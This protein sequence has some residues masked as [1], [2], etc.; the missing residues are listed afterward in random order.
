MAAV[1]K[2]LAKRTVILLGSSG[3]GSKFR[4][5]TP[6]VKEDSSNMKADSQMGCL[7]AMEGLHRLLGF[8]LGSLKMA[9]GAV[10]VV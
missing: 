8:S 4:E 9:L 2:L 6:G 7:L 3:M 1:F 5:S 10:M